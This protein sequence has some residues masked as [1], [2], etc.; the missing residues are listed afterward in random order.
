MSGWGSFQATTRITSGTD[1]ALRMAS[2]SLALTLECHWQNKTK[3][4]HPWSKKAK[5]EI[6]GDIEIRSPIS[7]GG[8]IKNYLPRV[9]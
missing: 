7:L 6:Q 2:Q 5:K 9:N 3:I 1:A 4:L 8:T